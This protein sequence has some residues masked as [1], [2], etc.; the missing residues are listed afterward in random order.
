MRLYCDNTNVG[1]SLGPRGLAPFVG[2]ACHFPLGGL[3]HRPGNQNTTGKTVPSFLGEPK[4]S[5]LSPLC[6]LTCG[7][8]NIQKTG[9]PPP[10]RTRRSAA[11]WC[12]WQITREL[13]AS[14][15]GRNGT[16]RMSL[17]CRGDRR[18]FLVYNLQ[19]RCAAAAGIVKSAAPRVLPR[20][21]VMKN[22]T[23]WGAQELPLRT[24]G[25]QCGN[26]A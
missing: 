18:I 20:E 10:W 25:A 3:P 26:G 11:A 16:D 22:G 19:V 17:G 2:Y 15:V 6:A 23:D 12:S 13:C 14:G 4:G 24:A 5:P 1:S 9:T 7:G 21:T 8:Y